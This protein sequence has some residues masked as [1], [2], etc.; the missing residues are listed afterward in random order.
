MIVNNG[1]F[2]YYMET[3]PSLKM[4]CENGILK[5]VSYH[6]RMCRDR[7]QG[8]DQIVPQNVCVDNLDAVGYEPNG[9]FKCVENK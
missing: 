9:I 1:E 3:Q 7:I 8:A 5:I 4:F 2:C 6:D